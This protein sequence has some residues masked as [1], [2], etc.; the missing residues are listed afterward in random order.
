MKRLLSFIIVLL[1]CRIVAATE[2]TCYA[3]YDDGNDSRTWAQVQVAE[4]PA[5]QITKA[6]VLAGDNTSASDIINV[7]VTASATTYDKLSLTNNRYDSKTWNITRNGANTVTIGGAIGAFYMDSTV[8]GADFNLTNLTFTCSADATWKCVWLYNNAD[9][10]MVFTGCTLEHTGSFAIDHQW[11]TSDGFT[12]TFE[13]S[14]CTITGTKDLMAF[15]DCNEIKFE[16]CTLTAGTGSGDDIFLIGQDNPN[17]ARII[18]RDS[19][20][21]AGGSTFKTSKDEDEDCNNVNYLE[22]IDCTL[23]ATAGSGIA[24]KQDVDKAVIT[25]N[26]I[27][28]GGSGVIIGSDINPW[29]KTVG[30]IYFANN[31]VEQIGASAH[32]LAI[33]DGAHNGVYCHNF[34]K[35]GNYAFVCKGQRNKIHHNIIEGPYG[36]YVTGTYD[37]DVASHNFIYANTVYATS[38]SAAHIFGKNTEFT[39][40]TNNIFHGGGGHYA[41]SGPIDSHCQVLVDWNCYNAGVSGL[42]NIKGDTSAVTVADLQALWES[43]ISDPNDRHNAFYT[44][45]ENSIVADPLFINAG[46]GTSA[47]YKLK[48]NS[49]C[50]NT[51]QPTPGA[52]YT[53]IGGWQR[54]SMLGF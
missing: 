5:K 37:G 43:I 41:I 54:K 6:L 3:D 20:L 15:G 48:S 16:N 8:D 31:T 10:N 12:G 17:I 28:A 50:L 46:G 25:G 23:T 33:L 2:Y 36:I 9:A 30:Y 22:I 4:T 35:G 51:G 26:T 32:T 53:S 34:I 52:G 18:I 49:P 40:A 7:L 13:F 39:C 38:G 21:T 45:D 47:S 24:I 27:T 1:L 42:A 11:H 29:T 14:N 44:N 19:N